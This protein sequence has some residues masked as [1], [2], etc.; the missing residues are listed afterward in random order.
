MERL[1]AIPWPPC[2]RPGRHDESAHLPRIAD[3][4]GVA[5]T[6]R[7][8][9]T[10]NHCVDRR[11]APDLA[12]RDACCHASGTEWARSVRRW[13]SRFRNARASAHGEQKSSRA[14]RRT[15]SCAGSMRFSM[16]WR[17]RAPVSP[18]SSFS[19]GDD[20]RL[21]RA[22]ICV[23]WPR[24]HPSRSLG[25]RIGA[26]RARA[27]ARLSRRVECFFRCVGCSRC[28]FLSRPTRDACCALA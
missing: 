4:I 6:A 1:L 10:S 15:A 9:S 22:A 7:K 17:T 11:K 21:Y 8:G 16:R 3:P 24:R 18:R 23:Y 5:S 2:T 14:R 28:F 19:C 13:T 20:G 25:G 27:R 12:H 26:A